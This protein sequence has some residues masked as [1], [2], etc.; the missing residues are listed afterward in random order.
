MACSSCKKV[1]EFGRSGLE[2]VRSDRKISDRYGKLI[3]QAGSVVKKI[4]SPTGGWGVNFFVNDIRVTFD[5]GD[6]LTIFNKVSENFRLNG[7]SYTDKDLWFNL[8]LQWLQRQPAKYRVVGYEE[9]L[10]LADSSDFTDPADSHAK[11]LWHPEDWQ[12]TAFS[13]LALYLSSP[14]YRYPD[15][16][17]LVDHLLSMYN[18]TKS[19]LTG[20]SSKYISFMSTVKK[21]KDDPQYEVTGARQWLYSAYTA[22]VDSKKEE[23]AYFNEN[24]WL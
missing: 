20:S 13:F 9:F 14:D 18:P 2:Y 8:N 6:P 17:V 21:L 10:T 22:T 15:F 16:I 23:S 24:H 3:P 12:E 7:V 5:G 11:A 1:V 4:H 19:P